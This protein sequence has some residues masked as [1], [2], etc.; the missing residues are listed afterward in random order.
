MHLHLKIIG[1]LL[2]VLALVHVFF[3]KYFKWKKELIGM[4]LINQQMMTTHTFFVALTV[5]LM[6]ILCLTSATE[7]VQ[8]ELGKRIAFGLGVFWMIRLCFQLFVYSSK[9]WIGKRFESSIHILF[10]FL[11]F[12]LSTIFFMIA[13]NYN[14]N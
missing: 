2:I 4:S 7:L 13:F 5:F 14:L 6:G 9:L 10:T 1:T 11:W 8:T 3:P 12:Y